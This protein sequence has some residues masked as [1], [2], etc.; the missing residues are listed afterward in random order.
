[1]KWLQ[2]AE[3]FETASD[4]ISDVLTN[5]GGFLTDSDFHALSDIMTGPWGLSNFQQVIIGEE[6]IDSIQFTR[7][8]IALAEASAKTILKRHGDRQAET[9]LQMMHEMLKI[10]GYPVVDD[11]VSPQTF[12]FWSS[13]VEHLLDG[14]FLEDVPEPGRKESILLAGKR[15]IFQAIQEF[16]MKIKIP[17]AEIAES[18]TKD[19]REGFTS[20]RK[21]FADLLETAYPLLHEP[22]FT[23]FVEHVLS[24]LNTPDWEVGLIPLQYA[25]TS[26]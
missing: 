24:G 10:P 3:T 21:D 22:L 5:Y 7:L 20:F 19:S 11:E 12:E 4:F 1:M 8:I 18:W 26:Y 16:W 6:E 15:H 25:V 9:L 23:T 14:E 2:H 17:P 13:L